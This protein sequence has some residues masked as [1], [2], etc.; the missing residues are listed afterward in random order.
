MTAL[1]SPGRCLRAVARE[2]AGRGIMARNGRTFAART[3]A[4]IPGRLVAFDRNVYREVGAIVQANRRVQVPSSLFGW[5]RRRHIETMTLGIRRLVDWDRCT[6]SL[7]RLIEEIAGH[8][9]VLT[10]RRFIRMPPPGVPQGG[11]WGPE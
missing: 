7:V 3:L 11:V 9:E 2:L 10:R 8:L 5:M 4:R 6:I 1:W